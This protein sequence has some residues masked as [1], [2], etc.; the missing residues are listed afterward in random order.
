MISVSNKVWSERQIEQRIIDKVSQH[1]SLSP[2]LSKLVANRNF[3]DEE[4][5]SINNKINFKNYF[6]K[7]KDFISASKIIENSIRNNEKICIFGDYDVDGSCATTLLIRFLKNINHP[8]FYF[9]PDRE[10]DGYGPSLKTLSKLIN[11]KPKLVIMVDCGSSSNKSIDFLK[12]KKIKSLIIDHHQIF[13]PFPLANEIINPNK[14]AEYNNFNYFCATTLT[15]FLID[16]IL[17][18]KIINTK[19]NLKSHLILVLL[20]TVCDVMPLRGLNRIMAINVLNNISTYHYS[21]FK[22]FIKTLIINKKINIDDL[23]FLIGPILNSGGR[24]GHSDYATRLLSSNNEDE[25]LKISNKLV[26]LN[27]VRKEIEI[28]IMKKINLKEIKNKLDEV[29][30]VYNP[31]FK[32]GLIGIIASRLK[33]NLNRPAFVMTSTNSLVKG[34]VRSILNFDVGKIL[35][36]ALDQNLI[37]SGGG[38]QMAG[39]FI[40]KKSK[41]NIFKSFLDTEFNK[42]QKNKNLFNFD[43]KLSIAAVNNSLISDINNLEPFGTG[44]PNPIFLF[45]DLKIKNVRVIKNKHVFNLFISR[46]G[47]SVSA[48]SFNSLDNEI[49]S[50]LLNYKK[51]VNVVGYLK[52]NSWNNKKI[53]QVVVLDL[54]L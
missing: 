9:I 30:F 48:I 41:L 50:C 38:H 35:R 20:A 10:K 1:Y 39:G 16:T 24:L 7:N 27:E 47:K 21:T 25:V 33:D 2:F 36:K 3:S 49:G 17:Y 54:I 6:I 45:E 29:I 4:I 22:Y 51:E 15:Y 23:G 44:N 53:L 28:K 11:K 13:K 34:S 52:D 43:S 46:T 12:S 37:I 40:I 32:D 26:D 5:Y 42:K 31:T 14:N 18:R 19:F 8:F